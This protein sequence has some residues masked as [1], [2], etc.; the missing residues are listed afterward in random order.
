M[1]LVR[2]ALAFFVL[3]FLVSVTPSIAA[4]SSKSSKSSHSK[5]DTSTKTVHV[6]S[7]KRKDGAVVSAHTRSAPHTRK[8]APRAAKPSTAPKVKAAAPGSA[9]SSRASQS[10]T[11]GRAPNGRI[12]RSEESKRQFMRQTGYP[13]GRPG[14][15]IDH[16]KPLACGGAD[17]PGNMQWQTVAEAK[18]K[19]KVERVGCR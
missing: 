19:D 15:V 18:A 16:I 14:Y 7:Y 10:V 3:T 1:K 13:N 17:A 11:V 9:P 12:V 6:R 2:L 8:S 4:S 5:K